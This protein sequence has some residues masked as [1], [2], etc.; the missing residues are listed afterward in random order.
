MQQEANAWTPNKDELELVFPQ[1]RNQTYFI[2][3]TS[4]INNKI[5]LFTKTKQAKF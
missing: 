2:F 4:P 3:Y 1:L 5:Y